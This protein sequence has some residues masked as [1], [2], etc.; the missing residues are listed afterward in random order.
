MI[1]FDF[2][3]TFKEYAEGISGANKTFRFLSLVGRVSFSILLIWGLWTYL[4]QDRDSSAESLIWYVP[5]LVVSGVWC[6]FP[7]L[8]ARL[9]WKRNPNI[10]GVISCEVGE[11]EFRIWNNNSTTTYKWTAFINSNE[12]RNLFLLFLSKQ[13]CVLIPKRTF[14]DTDQEAQFRELLQR[15]IIKQ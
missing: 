14:T 7:W 12:T 3:Y 2:E 13:L 10:Q 6:F 5:S 8:I 9:A 15:K 4:F 11:D 1:A